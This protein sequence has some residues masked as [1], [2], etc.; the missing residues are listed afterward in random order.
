MFCP[1]CGKINPDT[2][3]KC[4]GCGAELREEAPAPVKKSNKTWKIA[5][6][7]IAVVAVI[8]VAVVLLSG[9]GHAMMP[10]INDRIT[11]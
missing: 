2:E 11:Y 3:V 4:S 9:C 8:V 6:A 7:T 5:L 10:D 1:K